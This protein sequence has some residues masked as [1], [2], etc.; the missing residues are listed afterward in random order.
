[1]RWLS[2]FYRT[3]S[4]STTAAVTQ[5]PHS[6]ANLPALSSLSDLSPL[7]LAL[8]AATNLRQRCR[9]LCSHKWQLSG[10]SALDIN[11]QTYFC[12]LLI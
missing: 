2:S 6:I 1:L 9:S 5:N 7:Q 12:S 11:P 8:T 4:Q 10:N 3:L